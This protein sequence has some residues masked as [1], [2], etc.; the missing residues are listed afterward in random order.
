MHLPLTPTALVLTPCIY[1][2]EDTTGQLSPCPPTPSASSTWSLSLD[3]N[4]PLQIIDGFGAAWTDATTYLFDF[5]PP[6]T[7]SSLLA[8]L[9]TSSGIQL[10]FVRT[11]I[12]QSDLTPEHDGRW[13]FDEN[14]GEPDPDLTSW[15]LTEPG[16]HMLNHVKKMYDISPSITLL[17]SIWSPPGWMIKGNVLNSSYTQAYVG[18]ITNHLKAYKSSGVELPLP[19]DFET[20]FAFQKA[21]PGVKQYMTECWLHDQSGEQF[22]D[23]PQFIMRPIQYG[24]S[25]SLAWTLAG[26]VDLDVSYSGGCKECT[27]IV[28]VDMNMGEF[29]KNHDWYALGHFSKF[30]RKGARFL[31]IDGDYI[32][33][34]NTGV[35]SAGFINPNGSIIVDVMNKFSNDLEVTI[36]VDGS[37]V[38]QVLAAKSLTTFILN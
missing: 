35:E 9:F 4:S 1:T 28:Q 7:T 15:S 21:N 13:S 38:V 36:K 19:S 24:A 17:G 22:F 31:L 12:G 23:L 37:D 14:D 2:S 30:V 5:L 16:E 8:D 33:N 3:T 34:D 26:S 10:E 11:T 20:L 32:Y 27:G 18:Y 6:D 25:G 29:E